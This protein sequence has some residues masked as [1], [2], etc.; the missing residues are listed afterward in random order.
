M[1][2][3]KSAKKRI[4]SDEAKRQVNK[5]RLSK[6]RTFIKKVEAMVKGGDKPAAQKALKEASSH[7]AKGASKGVM[8]KK[9]ASRKTSRLA[10]QVKKMK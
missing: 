7:L 4:V 3:H 5:S 9:T 8:H 10:S 1:A 6:I 2:H